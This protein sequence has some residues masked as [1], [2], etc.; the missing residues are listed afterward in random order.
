MPAWNGPTESQRKFA[1]VRQFQILVFLESIL[2]ISYS[3][4][5]T[6]GVN[7]HGA[8]CPAPLKYENK[9]GNRQEQLTLALFNNWINGG[10][11]ERVGD[12]VY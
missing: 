5:V 10:S 2:C 1:K 6:T 7:W 8:N 4:D 12:G 11:L 3:N 9:K